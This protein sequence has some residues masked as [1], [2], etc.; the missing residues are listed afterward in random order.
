MTAATAG[1][2]MSPTMTDMA[3]MATSSAAGTASS[4]MS[5]SGMGMGNGCKIS[6]IQPQDPLRC[7]L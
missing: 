3:G 1:M 6:V 2:A 5:M 7:Q 4:G